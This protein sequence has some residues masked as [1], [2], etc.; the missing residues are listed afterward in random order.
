MSIVVQASLE[1]RLKEKTLYLSKQNKN[2]NMLNNQ[3]SILDTS[4]ICVKDIEDSKEKN[5][6]LLKIKKDKQYFSSIASI[7]LNRREIYILTICQTNCQIDFKLLDS[8]KKTFRQ[9]KK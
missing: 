2:N 1:S 5:I 3:K 6:Q 7:K 9:D 8:R 4:I